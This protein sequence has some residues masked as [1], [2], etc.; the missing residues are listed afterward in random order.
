[1]KI[2]NQ[3]VLD[4]GTL[5]RLE[6]W[7][8]NFPFYPYGTTISAYP[9]RYLQIRAQ[10]DFQTHADAK[11]IY[12]KLVQGALKITDVNFTV[13]KSGGNRVPLK[14]ILEKYFKSIDWIEN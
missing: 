11:A 4:D 1:M 7:N 9:K 6:D 14:P 2:L 8:E 5:V 12:D 10:A 13:M 3:T